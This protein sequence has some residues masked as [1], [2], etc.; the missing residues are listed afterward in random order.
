MA[1]VDKKAQEMIAKRIALIKRM[2]TQFVQ[3]QSMAALRE[4]EMHYTDAPAYANKYYGS[5]Y[6][7]TTRHDSAWD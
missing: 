2:H 6:R 4:E 7:E 5:V 3:E 1:K